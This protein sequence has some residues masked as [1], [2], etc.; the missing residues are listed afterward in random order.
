M[1]NLARHPASSSEESSISHGDTQKQSK[2]VF[3][4]QFTALD[5]LKTENRK[6]KTVF[7][8]RMSSVEKSKDATPLVSVIIPAFN[9]GH[10]IGQTFDSLLKQTYLNWE[11]LVIDDGSTD[12]TEEIVRDF[13]RLEPRV[14][15]FSQA[16]SGLS[17]ARNAGVKLSNGKYIQFLDADDLLEKRKLEYHVKHLEE[18][19]EVDI[20]YGSVRYFT[21]DN[22]DERRYSI[23]KI[24]KPWM[25]EVSGAG[26]EVLRFLLYENI[27]VVSA[28][29][30][31]REVI[32]D[33]GLFDREIPLLEDWDYWIRCA[34]KG[35]RF[36]YLDKEE[37][38]SLVRWHPSSISQ[39]SMRMRKQR[40]LM[41][42][43]IKSMISDGRLLRLNRDHLIFSHGQ[44]G[45][46]EIENGRLIN[47]MRYLLKAAYLSPGISTKLKWCYWAALIPFIPRDQFSEIVHAPIRRSAAVVLRQKFKSHETQ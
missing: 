32:A 2:S 38:L 34:I 39:N 15:Y 25:P 8:R 33:V 18:H 13:S 30:I 17:A 11:C 28:P 20:V 14:K 35:K 23:F 16:N 36:Q 4:L 46:D 19:Q 21:T 24:D 26:E 10:L 6:L 42:D 3:G 5:E 12:N 1:L 37:T 22:P 45:I 31:R 43:K 41:R 44:N 7:L 47:G 40:E 27:M 9:Y 29:L